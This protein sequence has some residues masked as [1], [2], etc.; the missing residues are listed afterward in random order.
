MAGESSA[1]TFGQPEDLEVRIHRECASVTVETTDGPQEIRRIQ[2]TQNKISG[3]FALTSRPCPPF[4][5]QPMVAADGVVTIGELELL[6]MLETGDAVVVDSRTERWFVHGTI[7][8]AVHMPFTDAT[9]QLDKLGC[10]RVD[11][12]WDC[13]NAKP[14]ALFCNGSW[15]GQ[16]PTSIHAMIEAGYPAERIFY[17]RGG[18]QDWRQVGLTVTGDEDQGAA[19]GNAG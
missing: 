19:L 11:G 18:I 16:S 12:G 13:T 6:D 10:V 7:P 5:I 15:C 1:N 4:C 9:A 17:Y 14:V 2:D 8:G 3:E